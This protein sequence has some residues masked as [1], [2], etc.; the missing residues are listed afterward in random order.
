MVKATPPKTIHPFKPA[1]ETA[2][3]SL[4]KTDGTSSPEYPTA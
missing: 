3:R 1:A 4:E 2:R